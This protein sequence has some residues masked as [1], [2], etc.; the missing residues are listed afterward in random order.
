VVLKQGL[1]A[2]G[3]ILGVYSIVIL[4]LFGFLLGVALL[5]VLCAWFVYDKKSG[6]FKA[7]K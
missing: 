5:V 4:S 3:L 6:W 2:A 7:K 1:L